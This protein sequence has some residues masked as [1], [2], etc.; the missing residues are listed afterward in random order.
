MSKGRGDRGGKNISLKTDPV[1]KGDSPYIPER[2]RFN[3]DAFYSKYKQLFGD[4]DLPS[5]EFLTWFIG[6]LEGDGSII[7]A[8]R[9]D[10]YIVIVQH[11]KDV[12]V[13]NMIK[14]TLGFGR[15]IK[16][17][18]NAH[19]YI[20][21][22]K[23]GLYLLCL[24]LN[25]NLVTRSKLLSLESFLLR[26]NIYISKGTLKLDPLNFIR[27]LVKPSL[28]D[29]WICGFTDAEGCFSAS[30][31]VKGGHQIVFDIAQTA[32]L[33]SSPINHFMELF[34]VGV[35][36]KHHQPGAYNYR[37]GGLSQTKK[38]FEYFDKFQ[39]KSKKLISYIL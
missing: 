24:L 38:L 11:S 30:I 5:L 10:F 19:R 8:K 21:Q 4:K 2:D 27:E 35:I 9:G 36:N 1:S 16:Q 3:Y 13:L 28:K 26:F 39:L 34:G 32:E 37:V 14:G 23:T 31:N 6:F 33:S 15:V 22:D 18:K 12:Q 7:V 17:S 29:A 25:G 20:V